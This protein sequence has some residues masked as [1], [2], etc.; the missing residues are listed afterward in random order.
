MAPLIHSRADARAPEQSGR[1]SSRSPAEHK[2]LTQNVETAQSGAVSDSDPDPGLVPGLYVTATPIGN[3]ADLTLRALTVLKHCDT[4][5]AEDTRVTSRLLALYGISRPLLVYNDHNGASMRPKLLAKLRAGARL[6]LVSDAGTPLVSDPGHRLV[7]AALEEGL[8]VF[9]IPG[10][11]AVLA[12]LTVSGLPSDRFFFAG[13]LPPKS[14]ERRSR[15]ESLKAVPATLI[16]FESANRLAESLGE[17]ADILGPRDA[18][19]A[20]ELTKLHEEVRRGTLGQ[21]AKSY[22]D[23]PPRGEIVVLVGPPAAEEAP[24]A[25]R[26]DALLG[27]ALAFM[28]LKAAVALAADA[29]GA[30]R[31]AVYARALALK[32]E[33]EPDGE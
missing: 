22:A 29:T 19:V 5:V 30:A 23:T 17:M 3:A 9:P 6:A 4:I 21:L 2:A 25:A 20:R 27:Q 7:R 32:H 31:R 26:I 33:S 16:F 11:S 24:D 1:D 12:G 10:A 8:P 18:A 13:F 14:G 28:P 15:I